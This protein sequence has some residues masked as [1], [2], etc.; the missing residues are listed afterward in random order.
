LIHYRVAAATLHKV[1][2]KHGA[3]SEYC[4]VAS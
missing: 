4:W 1:A 3:G 2:V